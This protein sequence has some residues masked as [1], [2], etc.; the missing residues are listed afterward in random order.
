[1]ALAHIHLLPRQ[2]NPEGRR[3]NA[4]ALFYSVSG[5]SGIPPLR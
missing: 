4:G 3:F 5:V 1:M 2:P